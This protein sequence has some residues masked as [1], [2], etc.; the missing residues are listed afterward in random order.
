MRRQCQNSV[1]I[2]SPRLPSG[3]PVNRGNPKLINESQNQS[4]PVPKS[5]AYDSQGSEKDDYPY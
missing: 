2:S 5:G 1:S 3:E 4:A